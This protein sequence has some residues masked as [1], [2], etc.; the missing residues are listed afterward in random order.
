MNREDGRTGDQGLSGDAI[1]AGNTSIVG[2]WEHL[3]VVK[4]RSRKTVDS[5]RNNDVPSFMNHKH[6]VA[7]DDAE[8]VTLMGPM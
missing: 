7:L 3:R 8:K 2:G 5:V 6:V 4:L 1:V